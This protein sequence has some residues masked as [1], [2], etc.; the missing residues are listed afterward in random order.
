MGAGNKLDPT[1]FRVADIYKTKVC[2]LAKVMRIECRKRRV[3]K[4]EGRIFRGAAYTSNRG[5]VYIMPYTLYL[6]TGSTAQM[7]RTP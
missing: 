4:A 3:K 7:H 2:P 1:A 5:Y 6:P